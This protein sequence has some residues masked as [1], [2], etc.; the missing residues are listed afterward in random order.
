MK[1]IVMAATGSPDVLQ[2]REL[3]TPALPDEFHCLVRLHAASV[4][5]LDWK[6][7]SGRL[8]IVK[9]SRFPLILG[10]DI[11]GEVE[12]IG[13]EVSHFAPGDAVYA[14]SPQGG[15]YAEYA[16]VVE[17]AAASTS[18]SLSF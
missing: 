16:L 18:A 17:E 9:R 12:A 13:A 15:G 4:N 2:L 5:P 11:A 14:Y 8:R 1:A 6:M 10:Y 7:R 3:P